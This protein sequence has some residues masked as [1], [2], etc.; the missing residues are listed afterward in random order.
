MGRDLAKEAGALESAA[1][2]IAAAADQ[3]DALKRQAT[4]QVTSTQWLGSSAQAAQ[5]VSADIEAALSKHT[6]NMRQVAD[7]VRR[8][9]AQHDAADAHGGQVVTKVRGLLKL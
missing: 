7:K 4:S 3:L 9:S 2:K 5:A 6:A 8:A 1:G